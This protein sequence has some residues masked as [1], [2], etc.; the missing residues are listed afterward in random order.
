MLKYRKKILLFKIYGRIFLR[1]VAGKFP[2]AADSCLHPAANCLAET[3]HQ[4]GYSL[5]RAAVRGG[6]PALQV[7]STG[8]DMSEND[9]DLNRIITDSAYRWRVIERLK[10]NRADEKQSAQAP[11][12][13][14]EDRR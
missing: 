3:N 9:I 1:S 5:P 7:A 8:T 10:E 2:A 13:F 12:P 14:P 4:T 6:R 11:E